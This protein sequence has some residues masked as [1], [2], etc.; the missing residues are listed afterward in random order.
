VGFIDKLL[1]TDVPAGFAKCDVVFGYWHGA[2]MPAGK[3]VIISIAPADHPSSLVGF[4]AF[5]G[6]Q[7]LM[8]VLPEEVS[9]LDVASNGWSFFGIG[10]A[11]AVGAGLATAIDRHLA[12]WDLRVSGPVGE[13]HL[14]AWGGLGSPLPGASTWGRAEERMARYRLHAQAELTESS[15]AQ[16]QTPGRH[17]LRIFMEAAAS[18]AP[19]FDNVERRAWLLESP[20]EHMG[21]ERVEAGLLAW[22]TLGSNELTEAEGHCLLLL[23]SLLVEAPDEQIDLS[24]LDDV[25][26]WYGRLAGALM[27]E[28]G[29]DIFVGAL[30]AANR[31]FFDDEV[32]DATISVIAGALANAIE[33]VL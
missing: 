24:D 32:A 30:H 2:S 6:S 22:N 26:G 3:S 19:T 33:E 1:G 17:R 20:D 25:G 13:F 4:R 23:L 12:P 14:H 29:L 15:R 5:N 16:V 31:A 10:P 18:V 9:T 11:G 27:G 28:Y 8:H 7:M 21:I